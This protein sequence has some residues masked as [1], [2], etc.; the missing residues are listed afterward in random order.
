MSTLYKGYLSEIHKELGRFAYWQPTDP[1]LRL[2]DYGEMDGKEFILRGN[3]KDF[4][5]F[6]IDE[7]EST[8]VKIAYQSEGQ[9]HFHTEVGV[10]GSGSKGTVKVSFDK[11]ESVFVKAEDITVKTVQNIEALESFLV[12]VYHRKGKDWKLSYVVVTTRLVSRRF[13]I[14]IAQDKD[15]SVTLS[16]NVSKQVTGAVDIDLEDL[17]VNSTKGNV[18]LYQNI[19]GT[20]LTPFFNLHDLKDPITKKAHLEEYK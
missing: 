19:G 1:A 17:S 4:G 20:V 9:V 16:G 3:V 6:N 15:T 2:G 7:R 10:S 14:M 5:S 18:A 12:D 11:K 13:M 8:G